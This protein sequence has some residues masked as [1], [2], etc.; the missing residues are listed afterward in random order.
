MSC[1]DSG[2]FDRMELSP[3][4]PEFSSLPKQ[5]NEVYGELVEDRESRPPT[6][7]HHQLADLAKLTCRD[8]T[9]ARYH[10]IMGN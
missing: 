9:Y 3:L 1:A 6:R 7:H 5:G 4:C 2:L 10:E 8:V